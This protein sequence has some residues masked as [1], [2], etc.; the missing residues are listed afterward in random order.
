MSQWVRLWDDMP[1]DPKWRVVAK[2]SGRPI[3]EVLSVF[4]H[5][6]MNAKEWEHRGTLENWSDEDIAAAIDAEPEHVS[7]IREAMQGKTL[8]GYHLTGWEKRQP[9]REDD[10]TNR[11]RAFREKQN[12]GKR[13]ETLCNANE[14]QRNA[15]EEKRREESRVD[16]ERKEREIGLATLA[17]VNGA[18]ADVLI[19]SL[20]KTKV[21]R[22]KPDDEEILQEMV[23][24]WQDAAIE[25]GLPQISD[26]TLPRQAALRARIKDFRSYEFPDANQGMQSLIAKIR[27]SPFLTGQTDVAFRAN[28]DW[29]LKPKNF[30]KI[31][32]GNYETKPKT[33][34]GNGYPKHD[35]NN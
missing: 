11:V 21:K 3:S 30:H 10:S 34:N 12:A 18:A 35:R 1:N 19:P 6:M 25:L 27:G 20:E 14:T 5:M 32:D 16:P 22:R 29:V 13:D 28:F 31:M 33:Y 2:R 17:L 4:L 9:K 8:D 26:I 15:P 24:L 7:A 23:G